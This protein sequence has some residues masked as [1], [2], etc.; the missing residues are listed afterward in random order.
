M[1]KK[2]Y[3]LIVIT[4]L[5]FISVISS[6]PPQST[7]VLS[8]DRGVDI[9]HPETLYVEYGKDLEINFWT[10][11]ST[12][13]GTLTNNSL[14][15]T[16]YLI[17]NQGVNFWRFSS[18]AGASGLIVY[19][20]GS[21]LCVNCWTMTM[22]KENLSIGLYTYQIKCQGLNAGGYYT[23]FFDVTTTG[24]EI[25]EA[26][27][28]VEIGL[29]LILVLLF[30]ITIY[31]FIVFDNLLARVGTI[32]AGY[33]LFIAITFIA[34]N[35]SSNFLI[36]APFV[37]SI[38]RILFIILII[39]FFP[40]IIGSFAWYILM[41]FKIKEIER[42]MDKGLDMNEAERRANRRTKKW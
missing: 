23:G 12:T 33:L 9:I 26:L 13:G 19:G 35:L 24:I 1:Y 42:L 31:L 5:C 38:F 3:L 27:A 34:W 10:Y 8:L 4:I 7:S 16:L 32:G 30:V 37:A 11:N 25:T 39:G 22:P 2:S 6:Q 36:T 21:P 28:I 14:N 20:K 41:L 29:L 15:C 17:D 18:Q 40:L